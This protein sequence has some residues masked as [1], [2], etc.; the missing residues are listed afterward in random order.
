MLFGKY[1]ALQKA[2]NILTTP[3]VHSLGRDDYREPR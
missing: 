3:L 1:K 2:N